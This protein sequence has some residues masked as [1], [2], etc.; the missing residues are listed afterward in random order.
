MPRRPRMRGRRLF[1]VIT[2]AV[3]VACCSEPVAPPPEALPPGDELPARI[4]GMI[5]GSSTACLDDSACPSGICT[6]GSCIGV[7]LADQRWMH[8][9]A[10]ERLVGE[11]N[12][13][14]GEAL[15]PR[16]IA[17]LGRVA[18][19]KEADSAYRSRALRTLEAI[20]TSETLVLL[21]QDEEPRIQEESALALTRMG[22]SAGLELTVALSRSEHIALSAEA[23]RALGHLP[24][25]AALV[26]LLSSLNPE[27]DPALVR[28]ALD[29]LETLEDR[30]AIRPL[31][32]ILVELPGHLQRRA[33][34]TLRGLTGARIGSAPEAWSQWVEDNDPPR[35]PEVHVRAQETHHEEGLPTPY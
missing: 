4:E 22:N 25:E 19:S 18:L 6:Y 30:R 20:G 2:A 12:S 26:E 14:Q 5:F 24:G 15:K 11:V 32:S 33:V 23:L 7:L 21:L 17:Q 34:D 28:A 10:A 27:L 16:V 13:A 35:A 9:R 1:L 31:V 8:A 3:V 29:G